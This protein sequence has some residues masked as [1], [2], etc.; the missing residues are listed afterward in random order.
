MPKKYSK[1]IFVF[2]VYIISFADVVKYFAIQNQSILSI[3]CQSKIPVVE[4]EA[5]FLDILAS[6]P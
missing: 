5:Y 2:Q 4:T 3:E 1:S 6:T